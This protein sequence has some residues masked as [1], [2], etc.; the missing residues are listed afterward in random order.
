M[1]KLM[2]NK[3][4][5]LSNNNIDGFSEFF[6]GYAFVSGALVFEKEGY[7]KFKL[8]RG[9]IF[10]NTIEDGAFLAVEK[11][12]DDVVASLDPMGMNP[13][14]YYFSAEDQRWVIGN[15]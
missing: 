8:E 14:Y 5:V 6:Q 9:S 4:F 10:S 11:N 12:G 7:D 13:L 15:S 2:Q 3:V 1:E